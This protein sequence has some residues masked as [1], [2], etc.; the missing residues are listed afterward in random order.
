MRRESRSAADGR[1]NGHGLRG[2]LFRRVA[3]SLFAILFITLTLSPAFA[4]RGG[5]KAGIASDLAESVQNDSPSDTVRLIISLQEA[6][7]NFVARR[8]KELG[9]A[10]KKYFRHVDHMLVELPLESVGALSDVDDLRSGSVRRVI[11]SVD[12]TGTGSLGDPYGHGTHIAGIIAG[13]GGASRAVG[14]DYAGMA[15]G[16]RLLNFKV[17]DDR[18]HG[19]VSNVLSAIDLVIATRWYYNTKVINLS[20]AA[21]PIDS[22]VND[23]LCK[24][25][26][27]AAR[28]GIVV[29]AAAGNFGQDQLGNKVYGGVTSPG[30]SP[31]AITVGATNTR[32]T[33]VRSDDAVAPFSS[34]GPTLSHTVDPATGALVYDKLAKP[35]LVAPG[36]RIV[37]LERQDNN[38]VTAYPILHV[39]TP[40]DS[41]GWSRYMQLSGTSMSTAVISGAVALMLQANPG[42]TPNMVKAILMYTA[43]IMDGPDL[44][45]QG[46]GMLN[47][48]GAVRM[49]KS[50]SRYAYALPAGLTLAPSGLPASLS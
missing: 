24:A 41:S 47:V 45:E 6:D 8:V 22:Y 17:L 1:G 34:R 48:D 39:S 40:N 21:P 16:V 42:L 10:A 27:Q 4:A 37:S 7:P 26:A 19:Y 33:D 3:L 11:R 29:V 44:F 46:A 32:G 23:A 49:A 43:Q 5:K 31:A 14:L 20:L 36:C 50:L 25:V 2:T 9:G 18:G 13:D 12:F 35:D 15:P 38:L 30:I 28:A